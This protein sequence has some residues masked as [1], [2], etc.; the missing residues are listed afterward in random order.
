M[1]KITVDTTIRAYRQKE[2]VSI[3]SLFLDGMKEVKFKLGDQSEL[4]VKQYQEL[5]AVLERSLPQDNT[6]YCHR[7]NVYVPTKRTAVTALIGFSAALGT[8]LAICAATSTPPG[9]YTLVSAAVGTLVNVASD[10][11]CKKIFDQK[12]AFSVKTYR[13]GGSLWLKVTHQSAHKESTSV[14]MEAD[15]A[16]TAWR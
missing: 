2:L 8:E 13:Y 6:E 4:S 3:L 9:T 10:H 1:K 14:E 5:L 11:L 7:G 16:E 12:M 15:K